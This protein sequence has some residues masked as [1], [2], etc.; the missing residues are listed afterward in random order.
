MHIFLSQHLCQAICNAILEKKAGF[1][2]AKPEDE[3]EKDSLSLLRF[4]REGSV[5]DADY[6]SIQLLLV[7]VKCG[8]FDTVRSKATGYLTAR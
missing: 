4:T 1:D 2:H 7:V 3:Q 8:L 6:L 5:G